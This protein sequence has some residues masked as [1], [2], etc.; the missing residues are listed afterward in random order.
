M[1][2]PFSALVA[3]QSQYPI[4]LFDLTRGAKS[5]I[6]RI[7]P[8]QI[9]LSHNALRCTVAPQHGGAI[10]AFSASNIPVLTEVPPCDL[11]SEARPEQRMPLMAGSYPLVPYSNRIDQAQLRWQG[12]HYPLLRNFVPESHAIHGVGWQ[13]EWFVGGVSKESVDLVYVHRPDERWPFAFEAWQKITLTQDTLLQTLT[14][15]NLSEIPAPA[16]LGWHPHFTKRAGS[17]IEFSAAKR[18]EMGANHIPTYA[19]HSMGLAQACEA[20]DVDHCFSGWSGQSRLCDAKLRLTIH[21]SLQHLVV[22]TNA[23]NDSIAIEPVSHVNNAFNMVS[24]GK[25]SATELGVATLAPGATLR[26]EMGIH[27]EIVSL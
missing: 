25:Y 8:T 12:K 16:G 1:Y 13:A 7:M 23:R 18:W 21:S 15:K 2:A 14:I 26:A 27:V 19:V 9:Q 6:V 4:A 3:I 20:L 11:S 10:I 17:T 24:S 22:Y 5:V